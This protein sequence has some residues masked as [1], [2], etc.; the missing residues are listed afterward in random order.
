MKGLKENVK[1]SWSS[2]HWSLTLHKSAKTEIMISKG[3]RFSIEFI[4]E[5]SRRFEMKIIPETTRRMGRTNQ[6]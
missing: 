3:G 5:K 6:K 4:D 1:W 2:S